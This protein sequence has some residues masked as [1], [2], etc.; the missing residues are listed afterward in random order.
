M[1]IGAKGPLDAPGL[2][3]L[4]RVARREAPKSRA[5]KDGSVRA[6][7]MAPRVAAKA[8]FDLA[9]SPVSI[10]R[11]DTKSPRA[12][13]E[14]V[15]RALGGVKTASELEARLTTLGFGLAMGQPEG[16]TRFLRGPLELDVRS[17]ELAD[18]SAFSLDLDGPKKFEMKAGIL[19]GVVIPKE[20]LDGIRTKYEST[21][22]TFGSAAEKRG[23]KPLPT[24]LD[25]LKEML[26]AGAAKEEREKELEQDA[27]INERLGAL[28]KDLTELAGTKGAPK[29]VIVYVDGPDGAGKSSTGAIVM[30]AL[31][32]A[33]FEIRAEAFKAPTAEERAQH[34]LARFERGVPS[35]GGAVYWDRGPAGDAAYGKPD[36]RRQ[37]EMA[38]DLGQLE[39]KLSRDGILLFKL[40]LYADADK[41]AETFGKRLARREIASRISQH[42]SAQGKLDETRANG[43]ELIRGKIDSDDVRALASFDEVQERFERFAALSGSAKGAEKW[44][45]VDATKRHGARLEVIEAMRDAV[46]R[47]AERRIDGELSAG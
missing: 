46:A 47:F 1:R 25:A 9:S 45:L 20:Q 35:E 4:E 44:H 10:G 3:G 6:P 41:Q 2:D 42:L 11:L 28:A 23:S 40:E 37:R 34:W 31:A 26:D 18:F 13:F 21:L 15:T 12:V 29:G 19:E 32:S 43:L 14:A 5:E 38:K 22:E 17:F 16:K 7:A 36:T 30:R 8:P 27:E 24:N 39:A 33:G